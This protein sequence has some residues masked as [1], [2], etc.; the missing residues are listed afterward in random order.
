MYTGDLEDRQSTAPLGRAARLVTSVAALL[1]FA[2]VA[3]G[4]APAAV[5]QLSVFEDN[6][7]LL[8]HDPAVQDRGLIEM[9]ALGADVVKVFV[10]WNRL[11]PKP[12]ARSRPRNFHSLDGR[13]YDP[14]GL[15]IYD[16]LATEIRAHGMRPWFMV[17]G[18]APRWATQ[19]RDRAGIFRPSPHQYGQFMRFLGNRYPDIAIWSIW[20]EPNHP[21]FLRP[22]WAR[23]PGVRER[24]VLS[25]H[26][27]RKLYI[28]GHAGLVKGGHRN[29]TI[30]F[31]EILPISRFPGTS[32]ST[33][34]PLMWLRAFLCL[35]PDLKPLSPPAA[36]LRGCQGIRQIPTSGFAYHAYTRPEG[37]LTTN[38]DGDQAPLVHLRRI[39]R[40]LDAA[41]RHGRLKRRGLPLW[42]SEFGYQSRPPDPKWAHLRKIPLFLNTAEYLTYKDP[43]VRSYPQYQLQDEPLRME[44]PSNDLQ[45]YSRFQAGLRFTNGKAKPGVYSA[46]RL[47]VVVTRRTGNSVEVWGNLRAKGREAEDVEIQA[48]TRGRQWQTVATVTVDSPEGYFREILRMPGAATAQWRLSY[49]SYFSR[50]AKAGRRIRPSKS[51]GIPNF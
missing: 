37:P 23:L 6:A 16:R 46:Y 40:V 27:Y 19:N 3:P 20:N 51:L 9:E 29:S 14:A 21:Q 26:H 43:R 18:P 5:N 17:G 11:A 47:P 31:G 39:Y 50:T 15:A 7:F 48:R 41:A 13:A 36:K 2:S 45:R 33:V 25:A 28:A 32:H 34:P 35:A 38:S 24:S 42:N 49:N 10:Q 4:N 1:V 30:L 44:F 12:H 22:T 8:N